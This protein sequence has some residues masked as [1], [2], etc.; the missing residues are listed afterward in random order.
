VNKRLPSRHTEFFNKLFANGDSLNKREPQMRRYLAVLTVAALLISSCARVSPRGAGGSPDPPFQGAPPRQ[1]YIYGGEPGVYGGSLSLATPTDMKTFNVITATESASND[2]LWG[3]VFRCLVDYRNAGDPS[4]YDAGICTDWNS[5]EDAK[6]WT[7][8]LRQ[9]VRWSDGEPFTAEDVLFTYDVIRDSKVETPIR[10]AFIEGKEENGDPIYPDVEKLDDY[11]VRFA[12][13]KPNGS[14]L[15]NVYSLWLIP[16]HKWETAVREGRFN[17]AMKLSDD[18]A[19]V[20]ALG[21]YRIKEYVTGER[22]VLERNPYFWKIDKKGQ[23]L[24]YLNRVVF[25]I[26]K[27]LNTIALKFEAGELD[28]LTPRVRAEDYAS[29]KKLEG[30]QIKVVDS[31]VSL[32]TSWMIFNQRAGVNPKTGKSFVELWKQRLFRNSVFRQAV[33]YAIDRQ[34]MANTIFSGRGIPLYSFVSPGD[35]YWYS[36]DVVRR[37]YDPDRARQMLS[38][39]GL[40]DRNGDSFLEDADGHTIEVNL[41]TNSENSQ[42]VHAAAF[43]VKNLQDVG[44]KAASTPMSFGVVNT[45]LQS[46]F[47]FDAILL[48]WR[49]AVPTGPSNYKN[50]LLS[51]SLQHVWFPSQPSPSTEWEARID[52][53]VYQIQGSRDEAE[54]KRLFAEIQRLWSEQLPEIDLVAEQEA[55]AYKATIGNVHPS[56]LPPRA[57]WNIEEIYF[58]R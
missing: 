7:F 29:V 8:H 4:G 52:Q 48:G 11:T 28:I 47:D 6:Q 25:I 30:P 24:P 23:R 27:D 55:V 20:V 40:R 57:T 41:I 1:P 45:A 5:S 32:N 13:H 31:G 38:E 26:A 33:S 9:G 46:T 18:P 2:I 16:K 54:R 14:F 22:I 58:A 19:D 35:T 50:I 43:I 37:P 12:L 36:E 21:P 39:I 51:S 3:H 34:G 44:I 15:D 56:P 17:Q 49:A 53:L 42:R 10:D